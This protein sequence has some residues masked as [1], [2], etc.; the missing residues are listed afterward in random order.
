MVD[1]KDLK[2]DVLTRPRTGQNAWQPSGFVRV[3][4]IP[5][6][7]TVT[8]HSSRGQIRALDEAH[9]EIEMLVELWE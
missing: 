7:I 8:K 2:V 3:Q 4:H 6:G 9:A 5:S 1:T